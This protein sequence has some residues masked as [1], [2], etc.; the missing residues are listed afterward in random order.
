MS[1]FSLLV[2]STAMQVPA[3]SDEMVILIQVAT[4]LTILGSSSIVVTSFPTPVA[5][6]RRLQ[7]DWF[8]IPG[9]AR[10]GRARRRLASCTWAALGRAQPSVERVARGLERLEILDHDVLASHHDAAGF[11]EAGEDTADRFRRQAQVTG[12][13]PPRH[14]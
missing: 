6:S 12:D 8:G 7:R 9:A 1:E 10:S 2:T 4:V 5:L 11:L 14:R 13:V 3:F